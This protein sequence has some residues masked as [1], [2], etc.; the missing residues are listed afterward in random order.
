MR[1][2]AF[3]AAVGV[4]A[5]VAVAAPKRVGTTVGASPG[6]FTRPDGWRPYAVQ[7][8]S[9]M[10]DAG[11]AALQVVVTAG[12]SDPWDGGISGD[13]GVARPG[14]GINGTFVDFSQSSDPFLLYLA[15]NDTRMS[16]AAFDGGN[17]NCGWLKVCDSAIPPNCPPP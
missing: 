4:C 7:C 6:V 3:V 1:R 15:T 12:M 17:V 5:A 13:A 2:L 11:T 9:T 10:P 14:P 8:I 16:V